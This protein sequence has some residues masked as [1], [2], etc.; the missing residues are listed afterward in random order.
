[1]THAQCGDA[2]VVGAA[3]GTVTYDQYT[4]TELETPEERASRNLDPVSSEECDT[5]RFPP[6]PD[7]E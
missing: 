3:P 4:P 6:P 1:V 7:R 2:P 5:F